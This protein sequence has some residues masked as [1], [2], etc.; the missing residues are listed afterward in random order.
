MNFIV[1]KLLFFFFLKDVHIEKVLVSNKTS[2]GAKNY[3]YFT[4]YL[5]NNNK[6]KLLL[7]MLP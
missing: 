2:F 1:T 5:H 4:G 3:K 7:I 6:V